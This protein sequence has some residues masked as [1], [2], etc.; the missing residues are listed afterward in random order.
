MHDD[1]CSKIQNYLKGFLHLNYSLD[2][3][4]NIKSIIIVILVMI[5]VTSTTFISLAQIMN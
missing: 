2:A 3:L 4:Y 5:N 1:Q